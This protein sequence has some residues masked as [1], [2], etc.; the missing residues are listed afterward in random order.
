M[1]VVIMVSLTES[2]LSV[3]PAS[4]GKLR[5][6]PKSASSTQP[7]QLPGLPVMRGSTDSLASVLETSTS[8]SG[9][10]ATN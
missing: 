1:P 8:F 9:S 6:E 10:W 3:L 5:R 7:L 4:T 2:F